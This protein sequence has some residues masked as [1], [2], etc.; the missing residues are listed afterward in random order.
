MSEDVLQEIRLAPR[1]CECCGAD[2]PELVWS[3][4]S[5][6]QRA[7]HTWRFPMR[8]AVCRRC[9]FGYASPGP[10]YDDLKRYHA[11]G[12]SGFKGIGLAYDI[13]RRI[14]L[15]ERYQAPGGVFAEIGGDQAVEFH[16][17]CQGLFGQMID[18]E[19]A[20][21][22]PAD[23][24]SVHD[25]AENSVNVVAHYDVLEHVATVKEFLS[26]C[27]RALKPGGVMVCEVPD[28]RLYPRNLILLEFEHVNHFSSATL[29]VIAAS[30]GLQQI[31]VGHACSRPYG[32]VSVYRKT[33][34]AATLAPGP[35]ERIDALGCIQGGI[36]QARRHTEQLAALRTRMAD[37][38]TQG[39]TM[40][41][42]GV[43]DHL[44]RLLDGCTLAPGA[45]VVD[46]DPRRRTHLQREGIEV[47][48]PGESLDH[49]RSS[50]LLAIF[51][52]RYKAEI[53]AQIE[54]DTGRVF[55]PDAVV[56]A[57]TGPAG[58]SLS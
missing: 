58:E 38:A 40:T 56:V 52:P 4:E 49:I 8:V 32:F 3:H 35:F 48:Q 22:S 31:E 28:L 24:R 43:T 39:K 42:W 17:R 25:L 10:R 47:H 57:G 37:L 6:V 46:A 45:R 12:L 54:K 29:G 30:V 5:L 41:L 23:H 51:A 21:D 36:E 15:L 33:G 26:A 16:R 53:L 1:A 11:E 18:V 13:N 20:E 50:A 9:G 7:V 27:A 55:S 14:S 44:R 34:G 2:D 19:I